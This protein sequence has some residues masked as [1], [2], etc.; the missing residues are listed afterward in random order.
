MLNPAN[1]PLTSKKDVMEEIPDSRSTSLIHG[2]VKIVAKSDR[3]KAP[4]S[5]QFYVRLQLNSMAS[6]KEEGIH[7]V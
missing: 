6:S 4:F 5:L 1:A 3:P 2:Y 7:F